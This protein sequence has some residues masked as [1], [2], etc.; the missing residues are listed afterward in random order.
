MQFSLA[1]LTEQ[2]FEDPKPV[3]FLFGS[4]AMG[5]VWFFVRLYL[6]WQWISG[7]MHKVWGDGRYGWIA[8]GTDQGKF[9]HAGDKLL[10][11]W[12]G[13]VAI[14]QNGSPKI[15]YGWYRDF[16]QFMIDHRWNGWFTYLIAFGELLVG[17]ALIVGAFSAVAALFGATMNFNFMLAGTASTNPMLF[18]GGILIILAW[19]NAGYVG[20]DRWLLPALGTPW[21]P[22]RLFQRTP[23]AGG[24]RPAPLAGA[25]GDY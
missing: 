15:T 19:K 5:F 4:P 10:G 25:A 18:A 7:A 14:P 1:Q 24:A 2:R 20:V 6:G 8:D 9:Y 3:K 17:I 21:Q 12:K 13:A 11:F 16:L 23:A 22:G